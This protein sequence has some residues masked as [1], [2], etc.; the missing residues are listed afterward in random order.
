MQIW[1]KDSL[2]VVSMSGLRSGDSDERATTHYRGTIVI[3][4][5]V[6]NER[7]NGCCRVIVNVH[8]DRECCAETNPRRRIVSSP[9]YLS[10]RKTIFLS[11]N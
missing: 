2:L 8:D 6:S 7:Y 1:K 9:F 11:G 3:T 4:I 10:D 5:I